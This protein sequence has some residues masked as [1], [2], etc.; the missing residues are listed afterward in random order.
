MHFLLI[1][2]CKEFLKSCV[3]F[4]LTD[5]ELYSNILYI[6]QDGEQ[7]CRHLDMKIMHLMYFFFP[8]LAFVCDCSKSS[9]QKILPLNNSQKK[10]L[11][12]LW[13]QRSQGDQGLEGHKINFP[14]LVVLFFLNFK[15]KLESESSLQ[16]LYHSLPILHA[17]FYLVSGQQKLFTK[18]IVAN[19]RS[20]CK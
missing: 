12:P 15:T 1:I 11:I 3:C 17:P 19:K 6:L 4:I 18:S 9:T 14:I 13:R 8:V 5:T 10:R 20:M 2:F 7:T 16:E